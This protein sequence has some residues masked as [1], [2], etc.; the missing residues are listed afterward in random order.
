MQ[1]G[2]ET[3]FRKSIEMEARKGRIFVIKRTRTETG[4]MEKLKN[5]GISTRIEADLRAENTFGWTILA[6][7]ATTYSPLQVQTVN[8][9]CNR[10]VYSINTAL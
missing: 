2:S 7:T 9:Q 1:S 10:N 4:E 5:W 6:A 8:G 3:F